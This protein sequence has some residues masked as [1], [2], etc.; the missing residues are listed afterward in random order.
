MLRPVFEMECHTQFL[1]PADRILVYSKDTK[2]NETFDDRRQLLLQ[3]SRKHF[4]T[5]AANAASKQIYPVLPD[6]GYK[7]QRIVL[8]D[9]RAFSSYLIVKSS[10][11]NQDMSSQPLIISHDEGEFTWKSSLS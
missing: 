2:V 7:Q 8:F 4:V 5:N 6:K 1:P 9:S 11:N 10:R 3:Q